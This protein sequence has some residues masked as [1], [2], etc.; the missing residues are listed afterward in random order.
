MGP[1]RK[2]L[3]KPGK[4]KGKL[5]APEPQTENDFLEAADD[6]EQA[7]GKWRAGDAAKATRFFKRAIDTY[8]EGLRKH[9]QSFDLAYNKLVPLHLHSLL[10]N[11]QT[12][13]TSNIALQKMSGYCLT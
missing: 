3:L 1:K 10:A 13:P 5:K 8:N 11:S 9:P 2:E 4:P 6:H 7:A 12:E